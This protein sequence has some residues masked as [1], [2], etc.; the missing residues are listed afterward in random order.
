LT[1]RKA[2]LAAVLM[3]DFGLYYEGADGQQGTAVPT[4]TG[5]G[6]KRIMMCLVGVAAVAAVAA[7]CLAGPGRGVVM[8]MPASGTVAVT[9]VQ[10]NSVW[11]PTVVAVRCPDVASR[12]VTVSRVNGT[13]EYPIAVV[14]EEAQ[15]YVYE[16]DTAYWFSLSNVLK[17]A[18]SPACTGLVEIVRE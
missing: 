3:V 18:V 15:S 7:M 16:F 17:V 5:D 2:K 10:A 14:A 1:G 13:L 4:W 9:N 11:R 12:T 8:E 6:M